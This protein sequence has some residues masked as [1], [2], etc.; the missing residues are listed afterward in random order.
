MSIAVIGEVAIDHYLKQ[1]FTFVGGIGLNFALYAKRNGADE[2]AMVSCVGDD[3]PGRW[4][5]ET[6]AE[7]D[8]DTSQI[9]ILAGQTTS[10]AIEVTATGER[11]FP[12]G[13]YHENVLSQLQITAPIQQFIAGYKIVATQYQGASSDALLAQ[14][15]QLPRQVK[16]VVDFGDW[17]TGQPKPLAP[18]TLD[19]LDLA[20][21]S[22]DEA[23]VEFLEPLARQTNC[24]IVV[25]LGAGG[26]VALTAPHPH[27][28]PAIPVDKLVDST[29]CGDAFQAAF[30]VRYFRD[31]DIA[32]ALAHGAQ[33]AAQ[34]LQH[35]GSFRQGSRAGKPHDLAQ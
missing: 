3:L 15:L 33:Q 4:V 5:L 2:V 34:V 22:G 30:A 9:A 25:T 1:N 19:A 11:F 17:A 28:Q 7:E 18:A 23:T 26:S 8:I 14:F 16:R 10:C 13:G 29:G 6:L 31:G 24:L 21:F 27:W 32:A 12:A 35:F 20:F